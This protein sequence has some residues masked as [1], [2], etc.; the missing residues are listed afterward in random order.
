MDKQ[1]Q[2]F[3]VRD[4]AK[5]NLQK[6]EKDDSREGEFKINLPD[7]Q[8][9][10]VWNPRRIEDLWD[11]LFRGFPVGSFLVSEVKKNEFDLLDGQQRATSIGIGL[12]NPWLEECSDQHR[13]L[14]LD[15]S[16]Q[17]SGPYKFEFKLITSSHPWGFTNQKN[18]ILE[19]ELRREAFYSFKQIGSNSD[20][21]KYYDF[22]IKLCWPWVTTLPIPLCF[23]V[24]AVNN[25][26]A[27]N[28]VAKYLFEII[29]NRLDHV[30]SKKEKI[31]YKKSIVDFLNSSD[32]LELLPRIRN[33]L[34]TNI[35]AISLN[36]DLISGTTPI[37]KS[38]LI[39]DD[40][41][42]LKN[43]EE[44]QNKD[45]IE[46]IF[47][48]VNSKGVP[49]EGEDLIYS[50]FKSQCPEAV[51]IPEKCSYIRPAKLVSLCIKLVMAQS[52]ENI[53]NKIEISVFK[54]WIKKKGNSEKL[55]ELL[56]SLNDSNNI[57]E[58]ALKIFCGAENFQISYY[59][60]NQFVES[61]QDA[62][63]ILLARLNKGDIIPLGSDLHRT[64]LGFITT[65][66]FFGKRG[67]RQTSLPALGYLRD[68]IQTV[69]LVK[70]FWSANTIMH[71]LRFVKYRNATIFALTP[72]PSPSHLRTILE[73]IHKSKESWWDLKLIIEPRTSVVQFFKRF[74]QAQKTDNIDQLEESYNDAIESFIGVLR[75]SDGLLSFGLR[76]VIKDWFDDFYIKKI[77]LT[78]RPWD[79]DHIYST[80]LTK[81]RSI[82]NTK[83]L[84]S[85]Q[86]TIGNKRYWPMEL[87]RG[88]G[89]ASPGQKLIFDL[90]SAKK[91]EFKNFNIKTEADLLKRSLITKEWQKIWGSF[92]G[93]REASNVAD[94]VLKL[95][96]DR[97]I[98]IYEDWYVQLNIEKLFPTK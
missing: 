11:S 71:A 16:R 49:L 48:R 92:D 43:E 80:K 51:G 74:L 73:T 68:R 89:G 31:N 88:A 6:K 38:N 55:T 63:W 32:F 15:I 66:G 3:E 10:F 72:M 60:L 4:I 46:E 77:D 84:S 42:W 29:K 94:E 86:D 25:A 91:D 62:F 27:D 34:N 57:F 40:D 17:K 95:I 35:P 85:W 90:D 93:K 61:N 20:K 76:S 75:D 26:E 45:I 78:H 33:L 83:I 19:E 14:W 69:E 53:P 5:W 2:K 7:I 70:E 8:R 37:A 96:F 24:E 44:D 18:P 30:Q 21:T 22:D 13:I 65:L 98:F 52:K 82:T 41:D 1:I 9:G 28:E 47:E 58:Q 79:V 23:F 36:K 12:N 56:I 81:K 50:I 54:N 67:S 87:N 59:Q 39:F 97:I 64:V